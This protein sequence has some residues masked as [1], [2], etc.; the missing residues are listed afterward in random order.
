MCKFTYSIKQFHPWIESLALLSWPQHSSNR[1]NM[2]AHTLH[3]PARPTI[4]SL[5]VL[6]VSMANVMKCEKKHKPDVTSLVHRWS[7]NVWFGCESTTTTRKLCSSFFLTVFLTTPAADTLWTTDTINTTVN[8]EH[9]SFYYFFGSHQN[10]K[11]NHQ[12]TNRRQ[13]VRLG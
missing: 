1:V 4:N 12:D 3:S 5:I 13:K 11:I 9:L 2:T 10:L 7:K 8:K 6:A